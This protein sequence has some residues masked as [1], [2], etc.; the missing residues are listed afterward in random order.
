MQIHNPSARQTV[1]AI[2]NWKAAKG[3]DLGI[4]NQPKGNSD[5]TFA[6]NAGSWQNK[7]LRVL[8]R[9]K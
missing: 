9:L 2:N 6:G 1:L 3:G 7:R 8:V 5:W 4:G